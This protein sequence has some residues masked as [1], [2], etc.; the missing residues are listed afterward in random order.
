MY[1][2]YLNAKNRSINLPEEIS[3]KIDLNNYKKAIEYD[4]V[5]HKIL[6]ITST[7]Y[8]M[9][10]VVLVA[11]GGFAFLN[12]LVGNM[13][14]STFF[15]PIVFF[16]IILL[17]LEIINIPL[18]IY[19]TFI[20][21]EKFGF[22]KTT[23]KLFVVDKIKAL[24]FKFFFGFIILSCVL[25][26][27]KIS[28]NL[29]WVYTWILT[30]ILMTVVIT[31]YSNILVPIFN[32]QKPLE[33]GELKT[34]ILDYLKS[35][36][37]KIENVFVLNASKRSVK[38]NAYFSGLGN[39]RRIVIYDTLIKEFTTNE[40]IAIVAH[41]AGHYRRNH[42]GKDIIIQVAFNGIWLFLFSIS[43][44][45]PYLYESL[46]A[47]KPSFQ[48][49]LIAFIMLFTPV[50]FALNILMKKLSRMHELQADDFAKQ[51]SMSEYLISA[52][53]KIS[54][55]NLKNLSPHSYYVSIYYTHPTLLQRIT[56]LKE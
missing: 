2:E 46:G 26:F 9:I 36:G 21:E 4:Q 23:P 1:L 20:V 5:N 14:V 24:F 56:A 41:E 15:K 27:Y 25:W 11:S 51:N 47:V 19:K 33:D 34:A 38:V 18:D 53:I 17:V 43:L 40:I 30:S 10:L 37:L 8:V 45:S 48:I 31:F 52:L 55:K 22:N 16:G 32:T 39:K 44:N 28:P 50:S 42:L 35:V 3:Q 13:A 29:F 7:I 49:G 6:N 12:G 54:S